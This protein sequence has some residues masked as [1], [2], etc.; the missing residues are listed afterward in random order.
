[1]WNVTYVTFMMLSIVIF[2]LETV[3]T[4]RGP[5]PPHLNASRLNPEERELFSQPLK[6]AGLS[7]LLCVRE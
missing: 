3:D 5:S 2:A 6:V 7:S 4:F 1:M